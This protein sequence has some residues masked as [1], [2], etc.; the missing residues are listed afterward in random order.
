MKHTFESVLPLF[1]AALGEPHHRF[2][3]ADVREYGHNSAA[4]YFGDAGPYSNAIELTDADGV[5]FAGA[6]GPM[7]VNQTCAGWV[8]NAEDA[9][10]NDNL[11]GDPVA[12][13]EEALRLAREW[14]K[15][16]T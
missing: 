8:L 3:E 10:P 13:P 15:V 1:V 4:W 7:G 9:S 12:T 16:P 11:D 14:A 6:I 2:D 5:L